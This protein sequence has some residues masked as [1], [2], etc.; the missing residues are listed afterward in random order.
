MREDGGAAQLAQFS[1]RG[2]THH[3]RIARLGFHAVEFEDE[4]QR[5][6]RFG[7]GGQRV[8]E[9]ATHVGPAADA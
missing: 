8:E 3:V 4:V 5:L 7:C 1:V 2:R 6:A 9:A